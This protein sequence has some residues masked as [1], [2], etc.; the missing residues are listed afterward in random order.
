MY[1][2]AAIER[3]P[4]PY[5]TSPRGGF[6]ILPLGGDRGGSYS[7]RF[8]VAQVHHDVQIG[9]AAVRAASGD[10][11]QLEVCPAG[12]D[13]GTGKWIVQLVLSTHEQFRVVIF[14][15]GGGG[16]GALEDDALVVAQIAGHVV[17]G[18]IDNDGVDGRTDNVSATGPF[19]NIRY[20]GLDTGDG[21]NGG[22]CGCEVQRQRAVLERCAAE[23]ADV[24]TG[25]VAGGYLLGCHVEGQAQR[26]P[27]AVLVERTAIERDIRK[28][29][30]GDSGA[31]VATFIQR[32]RF[33]MHIE[34]PVVFDAIL[35]VSLDKTI[36]IQH[37]SI[38]IGGL[39]VEGIDQIAV[40]YAAKGLGIVST[41]TITTTAARAC[42]SA[43][44]GQIQ[45]VFAF[46]D[47]SRG[48]ETA[49]PDYSAL[50]PSY[51]AAARMGET[52]PLLSESELLHTHRKRMLVGVRH[53]MDMVKTEAFLP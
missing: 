21:V 22:C 23:C 32:E 7:R 41:T 37:I 47:G 8:S 34:L 14:S 45:G 17:R 51:E 53:R 18:I 13:A 44:V 20:T 42:E 5:Q 52:V 9:R 6:R 36:V 50:L 1:Y 24:G 19:N 29:A 25:Q 28:V 4:D 16:L 40:L 2:F 27:A 43:A 3:I 30:I 26:V 15:E 33:W 12:S 46:G 38:V 31:I 10:A 35:V 48:I 11:V 49:I 39:G